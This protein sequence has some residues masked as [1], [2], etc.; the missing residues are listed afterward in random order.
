CPAFMSGFP[1]RHGAAD[2]DLV[3]DLGGLLQTFVD[4]NAVEFGLNPSHFTPILNRRIG[5][6]VPG[7]LVSHAARQVYVNEGLRGTLFAGA[8]A[9]F[10]ISSGRQSEIIA[11]SETQGAHNTDL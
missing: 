11:Q 3:G 6:R 8:V 10:I 2:R 7:F 9:L 1:V 4:E 5:L